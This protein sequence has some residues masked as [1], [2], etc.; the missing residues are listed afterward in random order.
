MAGRR[1]HGHVRSFRGTWGFVVSDMFD[2]DL[3]I[4]VKN[5]PHLPRALQ[6]GDHIEFLVAAAEGKSQAGFEAIDVVL[7]GGRGRGGPLGAGRGVPT[8][9]AIRPVRKRSRSPRRRGGRDPGS[10]VGQTVNG[11]IRSFR[12]TWGFVNSDHFDGDLF[13]GTKNNPNLPPQVGP[14][15]PVEFEV[16][17]T[18]G[19]LE[20]VNV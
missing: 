15:T 16:V 13:I 2:G 18:G 11:W 8:P 20:A 12:G 19:K 6:E 3:F 10:L 17:E 9:A 14:E 4:G 1:C 5:N 7:D